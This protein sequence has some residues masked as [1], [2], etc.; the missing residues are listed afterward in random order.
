LRIGYKLDKNLIFDYDID[1]NAIHFEEAKRKLRKG[2]VLVIM[3]FKSLGLYIE[4]L[5]TFLNDLH[6][7]KIKIISIEDKIMS[8]PELKRII[9]VL[10]KVQGRYLEGKKWENKIRT[11]KGSV[12]IEKA[13]EMLANGVSVEDVAKFFEV[14]MPTIYRWCPSKEIAGR[15]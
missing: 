3:N 6:R 7:L 14:S 11:P 15:L 9:S 4:R 8:N 2:D 13:K 10:E 5:I 1:E 12:K